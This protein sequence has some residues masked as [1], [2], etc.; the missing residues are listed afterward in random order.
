M[1]N[2]KS[3]FWHYAWIS[4]FYKKNAGLRAATQQLQGTGLLHVNYA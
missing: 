4:L 3:V 1:Q 2:D